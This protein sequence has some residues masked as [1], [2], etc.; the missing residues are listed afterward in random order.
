MKTGVDDPDAGGEVLAAVERPRIAAL[1]RAVAERAINAQLDGAAASGR[2]PRRALHRGSRAYS[3]ARWLRGAGH[4]PRRRAA[5]GHPEMGP[6][7][8]SSCP[9]TE[10][11]RA[12][13]QPAA[14]LYLAV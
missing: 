9:V 11:A 13:R 3:P 8:G 6:A 14:R 10:R 12:S 4:R 7:K 2:R 1:G 5:Y